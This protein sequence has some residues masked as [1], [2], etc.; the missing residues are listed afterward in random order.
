MQKEKGNLVVI[1]GP[2]GVGKGTVCRALLAQDESLVLSVSAT[3]RQARPGE[4]DGREYFFYTPEKFAA[5]AEKKAFLEWAPVFG[6]YY[7]TPLPYVQEVLAQGRDCLLEIDVQGALQVKAKW[8]LGIFIFLVP[9]SNE[10]L[11]Q[12]IVQRGTE[13]KAEVQQRLKQAEKEMAHLGEYDYVVVNDFVPQA[14]EKLKAIILAE[15]CRTTR[16]K[17]S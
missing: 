15:R 9:P 10:A 8:P 7:G 13:S 2:S 11:V 4:K 14:V 16:L 5:L 3:T 6:N 1:S 12:R 17:W